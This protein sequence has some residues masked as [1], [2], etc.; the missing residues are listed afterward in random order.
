MGST[1]LASTI[2]GPVVSMAIRLSGNQGIPVRTWAGPPLW[3]CGRI[4][5]Q[6]PAKL[7]YVGENP[8]K[9]SMLD[10]CN[11]VACQPSK[12]MA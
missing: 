10:W 12:L 5:T 1:P 6:Q 7:F 2:Y 11:L 9:S 4:S 8:A 3:T